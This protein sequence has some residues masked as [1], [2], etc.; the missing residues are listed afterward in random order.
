MSHVI[1]IA[2]QKGGVGKTTTSINLGSALVLRGRKVLLVDMDPQAHCS[3]GLGI[4][5]GKTDPGIHTVITRPESGVE[6]IICQTAISGLDIV[7]SHINLSAREQELF[8]Q[9]GGDRALSIALRNIVPKYDYIII[10]TPPSL[11]ML[12]I[13]SIVASNSV[14]ITVET[15]IYALDG[16]E[17]LQ[18]LIDRIRN[19]LERPVEVM[20]VLITR[21]QKTTKVHSELYNQLKEY[22]GDKI[23]N[24][25]IR[26]NVDVSAAALANT[27]VVILLPKSMAGEDYIALAEEVERREQK[28][29]S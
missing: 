2:N 4:Y 22:W 9:V 25:V 6:D 14:I 13:N 3:R 19:R 27:P 18:E 17:A 1:A 20:G 8:S 12:S 26:K 7:P 24:T 29:N 10:D 15:E 23:F 21:Y 11:G 28:A 5:L 16:M